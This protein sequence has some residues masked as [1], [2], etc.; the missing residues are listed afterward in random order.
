MFDFLPH[1]V[2]IALSSE[3]FRTAA[4]LASVGAVSI[5][6]LKQAVE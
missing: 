2:D 4:E 5:A 1:T 6:L 3:L